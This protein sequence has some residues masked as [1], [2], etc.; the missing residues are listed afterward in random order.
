MKSRRS[1]GLKVEREEKRREEKRKRKRKRKR[2]NL[3]RQ[4]AKAAEGRGVSE[5]WE[6]SKVGR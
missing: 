3:N 2:K 6:R 5:G 4:G 1:E